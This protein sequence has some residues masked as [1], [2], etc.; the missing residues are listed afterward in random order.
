LGGFARL[1]EEQIPRLDSMAQHYLRRV[2]EGAHHM[3]Q[4]IDD[5]L[6]EHRKR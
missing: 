3:G 1:L 5:L 4:L 6:G 2:Q